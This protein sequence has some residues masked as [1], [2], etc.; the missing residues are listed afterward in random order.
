MRTNE[1]TK[2][3]LAPYNMIGWPKRRCT[4]RLLLSTFLLLMLLN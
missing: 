1:K 3:E 2:E 4:L